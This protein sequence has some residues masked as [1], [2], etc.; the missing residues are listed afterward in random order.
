MKVSCHVDRFVHQAQKL[1]NLVEFLKLEGVA[2]S[3]Q[4]NNFLLPPKNFYNHHKFL[5]KLT[6]DR[7]PCH[8]CRNKP[9]FVST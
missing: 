3:D 8:F 5:I 7:K 2:E 9:R 1:K 6:N 4:I